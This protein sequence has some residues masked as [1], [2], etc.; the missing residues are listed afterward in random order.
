[1]S[2]AAGGGGSTAPSP[3]LA[4]F[5]RYVQ[6]R[7]WKGINTLPEDHGT[8]WFSDTSPAAVQR[9]LNEAR[10]NSVGL[11]ALARRESDGGDNDGLSDGSGASSSDEVNE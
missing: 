9:R 2:V 7:A 5:A 8:E 4:K 1:M 11:D 6:S 10:A 3:W